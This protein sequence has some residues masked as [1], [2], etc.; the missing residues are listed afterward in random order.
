MATPSWPC[1]PEAEREKDAETGTGPGEE[2]GSC[3]L[4]AR[5]GKSRPLLPEPGCTRDPGSGRRPGP[6]QYNSLPSCS[7]RASQCRGAAALVSVH[8][9]LTQPGSHQFIH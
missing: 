4:S 8:Y 3:L 6:S 2:G 5:P 1:D 9:V 7:S